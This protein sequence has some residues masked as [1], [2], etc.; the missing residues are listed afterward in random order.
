MRGKTTEFVRAQS[1]VI[2]VILILALVMTSIGAILVTGLPSV[3]RLQQNAET[4]RV[5]NE[6]SDLDAEIST[7]TF[8]G[9]KARN[10]RLNTGDGQLSVDNTSGWINITHYPINASNRTIYN[11]SIGKIEYEANGEVIAYQGGGVW[12]TRNEPGAGSGM[13]SPPEFRFRGST[14]TFPI[15]NIS[16]NLEYTG[17]AR[18][19][20]LT[21]SRKGTSN[22]FPNSSAAYSNPIDNGSINV[23]VQSRYYDA[24]AN[25]FEERTDGKV[26]EI[27]DAR[28]T[29]TVELSIEASTTFD[30]G[31]LASGGNANT[32]EVGN[33]GQ[34]TTYNSTDGND[35]TGLDI[36]SQC[37]S[38]GCSDPA[39]YA[40]GDIRSSG[41][42]IVDSPQA[43]VYSDI[44]SS[45][46]IS[47]DKGYV[48][49]D[50]TS[51]ETA[52]E[53]GGTVDGDIESN[54]NVSI[55]SQFP[56]GPI[57]NKEISD[58]KS[59][60]N[61]NDYSSC[62]DT[63]GPSAPSF[64]GTCT[65][66]GSAS[67]GDETIYLQ[68]NTEIDDPLEFD[69]DGN[70]TIAVDGPLTFDASTEITNYVD[71]NDS[72]TWYVRGDLS[73]TQ[74]SVNV[75]SDS[76]QSAFRNLFMTTGSTVTIEQQGR[77]EG[78]IY[79]PESDMTAGNQR[80]IYGAIIVGDF[81]VGNLNKVQVFYDTDLKGRE[82][83]ILEPTV[84]ITYLHV[85][86]NRVKI[87]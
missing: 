84:A 38:S 61:N 81:Q 73:V 78:A 62:I 50:I 13:L 27:N 75:E 9:A 41:E 86:E 3:D 71:D 51:A 7:V 83:A 32:L 80:N 55:D 56:P 54:A 59:S 37:S 20:G 69:L 2:G 28:E 76:D 53:N 64:D 72:I 10:I 21:V 60:N 11:R 22:I 6:F 25:Y 63:S 4:E 29:A 24:W 79:A 47:V 42:V 85:T 15:I 8:G 14:L 1:E 77:F 68:G 26:V 45:D 35:A 67:S 34:I 43:E 66:L 33:Q 19:G 46:D 70:L 23:T 65:N 16:S 44:L 87:E 36:G 18:S 12:R 48:Y 39:L 74:G 30:S 40:G 82:I 31:L 49:G 52:Q 5:A 17:S 58:A 57:V